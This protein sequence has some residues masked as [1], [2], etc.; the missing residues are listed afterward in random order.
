MIDLMELSKIRPAVLGW[1]ASWHGQQGYLLPFA[2]FERVGDDI[3]AASNPFAATVPGA[4]TVVSWVQS[5]S[6]KTTS[7]SSAYWT[8]T[9]YRRTASAAIIIAE[10]T[11]KSITADAWGTVSLTI[12]ASVPST[13]VMLF[14][15]VAKTGSPGNLRL[16][17]PVVRVI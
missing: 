16:P 9:L 11:T 7:S 14:I 2:S 12:T 8:V 4:I 3:S 5:A 6:V 17:G 13:D 10:F 1:T 15:G